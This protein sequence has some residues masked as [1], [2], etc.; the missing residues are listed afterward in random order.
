MLDACD[1]III[2]TPLPADRVTEQEKE[3]CKFK[4]TT[5]LSEC[6][7][8][9]QTQTLHHNKNS[10]SG[11]PQR[12]KSG[13][14]RG[15][16]LANTTTTPRFPST[17][18]PHRQC[19]SRR[20][21]PHPTRPQWH[22]QISQDAGHPS[23]DRFSAESRPPP[24]RDERFKASRDVV[25]LPKNALSANGDAGTRAGRLDRHTAVFTSSAGYRLV[26]SRWVG[27]DKGT[28]L[29]LPPF[30]P[31]AGCVR[32]DEP[33]R[34]SIGEPG[35]AHVLLAAGFNCTRTHAR[36]HM[37]VSGFPVRDCAPAVGSS[38]A[39]GSVCFLSFV[40]RTAAD[41]HHSGIS[42]GPVTDGIRARC[43]KDPTSAIQSGL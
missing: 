23:S 42:I 16:D 40:G 32:G 2:S 39:P 38:C 43:S 35:A 13:E 7:G 10:P 1:T 21:S 20:S 30:F 26:V 22:R 24:P 4:V 31:I 14:T 18:F 34:E 28:H 5:G 15:V 9:L 17:P 11:L 27:C 36:T 3:S 19:P 41:D 25:F 33:N 8:D 29:Q 6:Q 37:K 12:R